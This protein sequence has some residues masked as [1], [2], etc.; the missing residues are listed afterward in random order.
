LVGIVVGI[1]YFG[2]DIRIS[3][4]AGAS[5]RHGLATLASDVG[6]FQAPD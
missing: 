5:G 4:K 6:Q 1:W 3:I 2:K